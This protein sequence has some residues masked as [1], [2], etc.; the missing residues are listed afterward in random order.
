MAGQKNA[1]VQTDENTNNFLP[2]G[3]KARQANTRIMTIEITL[4]H[5]I[6]DDTECRG[7]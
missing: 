2:F 6:A 3:S 4:I 5:P 7:G 1:I